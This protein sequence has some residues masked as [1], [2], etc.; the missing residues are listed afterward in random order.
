MPR[1]VP[2]DFNVPATV[3][4]DELRLRMLIDLGWH[5]K[6]FQTRRSYAYAVR[7]GSGLDRSGLAVSTG[8]VSGA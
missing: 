4:T 7:R 2:R 6:G 5:Q 3:E 8:C 1:F